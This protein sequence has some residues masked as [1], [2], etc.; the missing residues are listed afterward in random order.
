MVYRTNRRTLSLV[1]AFF[2]MTAVVMGAF[3]P[4]ATAEEN[5]MAVVPLSSATPPDNTDVDGAYLCNLENDIVL[6]EKNATVSRAPAST[7]KI[8]AGLL[9]C[10]ILETRLDE[11]VTIEPVMLAG[12]SGR[13]MGL[14]SGESITVGDLLYAAFCGG[15]NDA[16]CAVAALSCGSVDAFVELMNAEAERLG[17]SGTHYVNPNGFPEHEDMV[18]TVADTA[19]VAR[20][21]YANELYMTVVAAPTHT[22]PRTNVSDERSFSN[23]N[24]LLSDTG[25][26][27]YNGW[28]RGM[29]A[30]MT[31][32][33]GWCVVTVWERDGA[34]NLCVV[35]GGEDVASGETIP[36]Y[37]Y[38][39][40]LLG[41][42]N[43]HYGYR[44]VA[45]AGQSLGTYTVGMTG[46]SKSKADVTVRED[47]RIYL[48]DDVDLSDELTLT[49][50]LD[51]DGLVAPLKEGQRVGTVTVEYRGQVIGSAPI[52]VEESFERN[53]FL[54]GME[55]FKSYLVSRPFILTTACFVILLLIYLR[56]ITGPGA[57]YGIRHVRGRRYRRSYRR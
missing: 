26:Q 19:T 8:M 41:W 46:T 35:M 22:V 14:V 52:V 1:L 24:L 11:T 50:I 36:A 6:H 12:A 34:A 20:A 7:A 44:T 10:R 48:P 3:I 27:Y 30:G 45:A 56:R 40:R 53:G 57:R 31:D 16:T 25:G 5:V 9:A 23:R 21:A 13:C 51:G 32:E 38:T 49:P 55:M 2:M 29:S 18:T 47:L 42:A 28:C 54:G 43:D 15:Y 37:S 4:T 39:N 17:A 33:G